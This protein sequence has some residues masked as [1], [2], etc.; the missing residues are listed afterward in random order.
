MGMFMI[1]RTAEQHLRHWFKKRRRKPLVLRGARQVGKSTLVREFARREGLVINEINLERHLSLNEV[2]KTLDMKRIVRELEGL[3]GRNILQPGSVLFLD[4]IQATPYALAALR[5][6]YE[7][8]PALPV[9]AAGSLL[10]FALAE[11]SFSMPVGRV[12]YMHIGP[13]S[14]SEFIAC[15]D[16]DL[17]GWRQAAGAFEFIPETA[18]QRLLLRLRE[19]LFVGG[20]PEAVM[21]YLET[22]SLSEVQD[23]HRSIVETYQDDFSKYARHAELVRLQRV[24]EQIPRN[25]GR[26][27]KYVNLSREE[28]SREI[29]TAVELLSL[30]QICRK[31]TASRCS[32][33]P[34]SAEVA[35]DIFKLIFMDT[36]MVNFVCGG[37]WKEISDAAEQTLINEGPLAEQF[38]GQHL[39]YLD[40]SRPE[41]HYWLR[42][43]RA[44]NAE[45]DYVFSQGRRIFP[46][47]VKAGLSGTL[48]SLQ[49]FVLEKKCPQAIR[50][51]L[52]Q[53]S[54]MQVQ[55]IARVGS[56]LKEVSFDLLSLPLY[57]VEAIASPLPEPDS[58]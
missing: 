37:R 20:M 19:F 17:E 28:R 43:G 24:F 13:L 22:G 21:E 36:G 12:E 1:K 46:V 29:K 11:H 39:A 25:I 4:E 51:D 3:I 41:L 15:L 14:F 18:H 27:I 6:F 53:P 16:P 38:V 35:D 34:L 52:N 33:V 42:E 55:A 49:Q 7:D 47:E 32:G 50:F 26:K 30:A 5:Y 54:R 45:V 23:V 40:Y 9:V 44:N 2:F 10:E 56:G 31:V 48:K 57:A 8:L 58:N